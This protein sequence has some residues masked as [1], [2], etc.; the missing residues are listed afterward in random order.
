[1]FTLISLQR[2]NL[3]TSDENDLV[4]DGN[5]FTYEAHYNPG[6]EAS[7]SVMTQQDFTIQEGEPHHIQIEIFYDP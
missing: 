2:G 1:M 7:A 5:V 3:I 4:G 6:A